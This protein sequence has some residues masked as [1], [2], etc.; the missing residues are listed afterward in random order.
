MKANVDINFSANYCM[1]LIDASSGNVKQQADFHNIPVVGFRS[2]LASIYSTS[3]SGVDGGPFAAYNQLLNTLRLGSGSTEPSQS[4]TALSGQLWSIL[5][6]GIT[7]EWIDDYTGRATSSY[8]VPATTA[9]VGTV[10][11][12]GLACKS[13]GRSAGSTSTSNNSVLCTRALIT[14]SEGQPI[15]FEKTDLDILVVTVVVDMSIRSSS[16]TFEIFKHNMLVQ[17]V[18]TGEYTYNS[19]FGSEYGYPNLCRFYADVEHYHSKASI[20]SSIEKSIG[21]YST[22]RRGWNETTNAFVQYP[23]ARLLATDITAERYY[24]AIAIP[25]VGYW[26]LPNEEVMPTYSISGIAIGTGDGVKTQFTNPLSYFKEGTDVVYKNGV[27]LTRGVDYTIHHAGNINCL[28]EVNEK[29]AGVPKITSAAYTSTT[30]TI[31]PLFLPTTFSGSP[32]QLRTYFGSENVDYCFSNASPLFLEY[33]EAVTMNCM[34]CTGSIRNMS[35]TNSTNNIPSGTTFYIDASDD[36]VDYVELGSTSLTEANGP[37]TIDFADTTA[38][39]WR[40]RT[41]YNGVVCIY[42]SSSEH[43][44]TL[45]RKQPYITFAEAPAEGDVITMDVGMDVIMKNSNFV[46]DIGAT[47]IFSF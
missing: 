2:C 19:G 15:E 17:N 35:G 6:S 37:F 40:L 26:K 47:L 9:Y 1:K 43:Y 25:G 34:K 4:D 3:A 33:A 20:G 39:Y 5:N 30:L 13:H 42:S 41:S 14:D 7:F 32:T 12:V 21:S 23:V 29:L 46:V 8:T 44:M 16:S 38:K 28:P 18:L 31:R 27:A 11:E 10:R 22:L 36:G 24:K 45:S